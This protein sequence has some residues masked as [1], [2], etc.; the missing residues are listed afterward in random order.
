MNKQELKKII[1]EEKAMYTKSNHAFR[2]FVH[3]KRYMIWRY[4]A[5]FRWS[6]YYKERSGSASGFGKLYAKAAYWHSMRK[7]NILGEKCGVEITNNSS[8]GR[9][10]SIWHSG[11]VIDAQLGDDVSVRGN[12]V[13]GSKDLKCTSGRPMIGN[14]VEI[15]FGAA[16]IGNITIAD[17]CI[18]GANAVVTKDFLE[19]GTTIV[20]VPGRA[21]KK[22][23]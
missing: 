17:R 14:G 12:C 20:G 3:Q 4:L 2:S 7:K 8:L 9:R 6:Q 5:W 23:E 18:I 21:L 1:A 16:L 15:G 19:P 22:G 10:L 11:V 13:L